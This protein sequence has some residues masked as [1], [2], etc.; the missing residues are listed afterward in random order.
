M[1]TTEMIALRRFRLAS[2][3]AL[4]W[5]EKGHKYTIPT[6]QKAFHIAT[7]RGRPVPVKKEKE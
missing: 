2:G 3:P 6:D 4:T 1:K 5:V 7:E